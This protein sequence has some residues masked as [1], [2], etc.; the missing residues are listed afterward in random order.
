MLCWLP[1]ADPATRADGDRLSKRALDLFQGTSD[2]G[3]EEEGHDCDGR[4]RGR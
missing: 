2:N 1:G 4:G 3:N